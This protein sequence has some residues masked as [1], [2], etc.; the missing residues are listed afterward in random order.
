MQVRRA[1][2]NDSARIASLLYDSFV[3]Y[4]S[5][6]TPEAFA[7][8]TPPQD[9]I[10]ARLNEGPMW[11]AVK[12]KTIVGTASAVLKSEGL[13]VRS[14]AVLP[15]ARGQGL[16]RLLLKAVEDYA[17]ARSCRRLFLS[18]TPFLC[19]AIRLYE[20]FGFERSEEGPHHLFGTPLIT[21]VKAL[22]A[23]G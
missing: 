4:K 17:S 3:E 5:L 14:M 18:T 8:T 7:A 11:V 13:Y 22:E 19:S 9:Q 6:Y 16:G 23:S 1:V 15:T 2:E 12:N 10:R 20:H 21:M